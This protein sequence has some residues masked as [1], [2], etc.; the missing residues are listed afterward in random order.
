LLKWSKN[1]LPSLQYLLLNW[2]TVV[3]QENM[4]INPLNS[5]SLGYL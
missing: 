3:H 2:D 5:P 1:S 4:P